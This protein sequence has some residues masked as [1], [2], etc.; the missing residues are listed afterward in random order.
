MS[1]PPAA[2]P[3]TV[4]ILLVDDH[5]VI[6]AGLKGLLE[7]HAGLTVVAE[8]RNADEAFA[9]ALIHRPRI[10]VMDLGLPDTDGVD[11]T[12]RIARALPETRIVVFTASA[13]D[14]AL[15]EAMR[16]GAAG[17]CTK[18][19]DPSALIAVI[20]AVLGGQSLVD[21]PAM[22]TTRA[23]LRSL[24]RLGHG[25]AFACLSEREIEVLTLIARGRTNSEMSGELDLAEKTVRNYVSSVLGKLGMARRSEAAAYAVRHGLLAEPGSDSRSG[26]A[27]SGSWPMRSRPPGWGDRHR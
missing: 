3:L 6:R 23:Q 18:Q 12:R 20:E 16:A 13:A 7:A 5:E 15:D 21:A 8:A 4:P 25:T 11:A 17:Y 9:R 19:G 27:N 24:R 22:D 26:E 14:G 10:V 1:S 2:G